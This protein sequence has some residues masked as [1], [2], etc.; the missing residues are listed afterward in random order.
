MIKTIT[1]IL[2]RRALPT[3]YSAGPIKADFLL[4]NTSHIYGHGN[5]MFF[6]FINN[7]HEPK[8]A[9]SVIDRDAG[10]KTLSVIERL[11]PALKDNISKPILFEPFDNYLIIAYDYTP[12]FGLHYY[13]VRNREGLIQKGIE[14]LYKTT[15]YYITDTPEYWSK[16]EM[17]SCAN[18]ELRIFR[19]ISNSNFYFPK[20]QNDVNELCEYI[21][22]VRLLKIPQHGDYVIDNM[23]F[24]KKNIYI[25]DLDSF[26]QVQL[27]YYDLVSYFFSIWVKPQ[28]KQLPSDLADLEY[29][30]LYL[31]SQETY[32]QIIG[33]DR[34]LFN[35]LLPL[36]LVKRFNYYMNK[37][38]GQIGRFILQYIR[39]Y[40]K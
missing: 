39:E 34:R 31:K 13:P 28:G 19:A 16:D 26:F 3:G 20:I 15:A 7:S 6:V 33:A 12:S 30:N 35:K 22:R 11:L 38:E 9:V 37:R 1:E 29:T 21:C 18:N 25:F 10:L 23:R 4:A 40:Y 27:P 36:L 17:V 24:S 8:F 14:L 2:R 5:F 32:S